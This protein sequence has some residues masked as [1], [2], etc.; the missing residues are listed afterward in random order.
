VKA[1]NLR[2]TKKS[3]HVGND[4]KLAQY[5]ALVKMRESCH[6]CSGVT[7]GSSIQGGIY[8]CDEVGAW[9]LWQGNLNAKLMVVGQDW[10]DVEWFL[11]VKGYPTSTSKTN[12][13]LIELLRAAGLN[14][15]LANKTTGHGLLFF[16][17][18]VLCMKE[19][20]AQAPVK[21]GW[22]RNCGSR[23][24]RPTI[25]LVQPKVVV[26]LGAKAYEAVMSAY[27]MTARGFKAAVES[28]EPDRLAGGVYV[29]PVYHCGAY[30]LNTHR[31]LPQQIEDWRRIGSFLLRHDSN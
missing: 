2:R 22:L 9:S 24:L 26:S 30:V 5:E 4:G 12:T 14:I 28:G 15:N 23:F 7:N 21:P 19:G 1:I 13:T 17:N 20:G 18:A 16:T 29:F 11:R 8:D 25:E 31:K 6:E 3:A 10:G 27:Q